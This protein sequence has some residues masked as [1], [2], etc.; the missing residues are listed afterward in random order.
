MM[1]RI[2]HEDRKKL[3]NTIGFFEVSLS[4]E[5]A[6]EGKIVLTPGQHHVKG[7]PDN[8]EG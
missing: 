5:P 1:I 8:W 3:A 4:V 2:A 7:V 6:W